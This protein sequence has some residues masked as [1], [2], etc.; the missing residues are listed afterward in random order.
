VASLRTLLDN[1]EGFAA[2]YKLSRRR[3]P[4]WPGSY[5]GDREFG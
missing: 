4:D 3:Q 1:D 2:Q 5:D